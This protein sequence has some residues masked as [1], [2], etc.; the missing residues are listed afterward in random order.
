VSYSPEPHRFGFATAKLVPAIAHGGRASI[1]TSRA[2][3]GTGATAFNFFD[4]SV[5]PSGANIGSHRHGMDNEETYVVVSGCGLMELDGEEFVVQAG[6]V[7]VNRPGGRHALDNISEED[8]RL[9]VIEL[10]AP[11]W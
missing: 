8:L 10:K 11:P 1:L 6:D 5:V 3:V 7:V 2:R 4:L 9:V